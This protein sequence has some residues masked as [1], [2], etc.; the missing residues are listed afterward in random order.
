MEKPTD[1]FRI[2][3][4]VTDSTYKSEKCYFCT[5]E[6][7]KEGSVMRRSIQDKKMRYSAMWL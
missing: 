6:N 7:T 5:Q 3:Y 1:I 4:E 2:T